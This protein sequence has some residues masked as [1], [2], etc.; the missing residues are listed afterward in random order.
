MQA[1]VKRDES[2]PGR[3]HEWSH[4]V[5][6][7]RRKAVEERKRSLAAVVY[8]NPICMQLD[9]LLLKANTIDE[10]L[11]L[12][13]TH[14]GVFFV[15]NLITALQVLGVL[16]EDADVVQRSN[17]MA[18]ERYDVLLSDLFN[19]RD[20]LDFDSL[21][22]VILAL[23][24]LGHKYF[25]LFGSYL[26][27]LMTQPVTD[28]DVLL[29]C[30]DAYFWAGYLKHPFYDRCADHFIDKGTLDHQQTVRMV[31]LFGS[32]EMYHAR[33][34]E[35]TEASILSRFQEF[36]PSELA[37]IAHGFAAHNR[38]KHDSLFEAVA[39]TVARHTGM[40]TV[41]E[42]ITCV[43]AF[44]RVALRFDDA[45]L[46][47]CDRVLSHVDL[48]TNLRRPAGVSLTQL[49]GYLE[50]LAYFGVGLGGGGEV[51]AV[52]KG[53][54]RYLEDHLDDVSEEAATK[55]VF[56]IAVYSIAADVPYA[57]SFLY[58]K[59]GSTPAW[60]RERYRVFHLWLAHMIQ[61]PWLRHNMHP[62]CVYEGM[63]TWAM[64]RGG[65]G[66]PFIDQVHEVSS[67]LTKLS[68]P[69]TVEYQIDAP[70]VLDIKLR[71]RR[72][73]LLVVSECSRNGL[74][75]CGSTLLQLIHLRQYGYN[76]IA[77]KRSHWRSLG[78]AEKAEY[79][80]VILRD[81]DVPICSS[82]DRPGEEEED[83]GAGREG[84]AGAELETGV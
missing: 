31:Q 78:A 80:E 3:E 18:D 39:R 83:Q 49:C 60:E 62:R 22:N 1:A 11:G 38:P 77:I 21:A 64:H 36:S 32:L 59:I 6:L 72:D 51:L 7:Q 70:Y 45:L 13:V 16:Y 24:Q 53:V 4:Q 14:R 26:K 40:F 61:F 37:G 54:V 74:Q 42:L 82:A 63:R 28:L 23:R 2:P 20:K 71:G 35:S 9:Q 15:H 27:P 65:F 30:A 84:Q 19:F 33:L 79:I 25:R 41:G 57:L 8:A 67:E 75:P 52:V 17:L 56:A 76:P 29:K 55:A 68:V 44:R 5:A 73:V 34:F 12:L 46:A 81:S 43:C 58:R 66:A 10:M 50:S 69:H 48:A 47:T